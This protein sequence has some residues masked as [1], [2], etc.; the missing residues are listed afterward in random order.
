[1]SVKKSFWARLFGHDKVMNDEN[2]HALTKQ[3]NATIQKSL[4]EQYGISISHEMLSVGDLHEQGFRLMLPDE[5][6]CAS[7]VLQYVPQM[8]VSQVNATA[9]STA[10]RVA[11]DGSYRPIL[12]SQM[13]LAASKMTEGAV[14]G[15][16]LSNST[17]QVAGSAEWVKNTAVSSLTKAPQIALA[18]FSAVS[19]ITGQYFMT[20]INSKLTEL[21]TEVDHLGQFLDATQRSE[22]YAAFHELD[23]IIAR[24]DYIISDEAKA[25]A[26]I[27]QIHD[28]QRAAQKA[29][30]L[31]RDQ[32]EC[33]K[34]LMKTTDKDDV[35]VGRLNTIGK[36]MIEYK[37]A[38][39]L[40]SVATLLEVR[41]S[42][43]TNPDELGKFHSQI[44]SRVEQYKQD[45]ADCEKQLFAY[46][47]QSHVLNDRSLVQ[48]LA[49]AGTVALSAVSSVVSGVFPGL[50]A[51]FAVDDLF[52]EQQKK[53]KD[54]RI[55]LAKRYISHTSDVSSLD[56]PSAAIS[57]FI[58]LVSARIEIVQVGDELYTN[59]PE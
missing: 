15:I 16:G 21:K 39:Q 37:Q 33:E 38:V 26:A 41:F 55:D 4:R 56:A 46:I 57:S 45:N 14:R 13:H 1:M 3:E 36:F 8:V 22:L 59:I 42:N 31:C 35:L 43:I 48:N 17:N 12:D 9:A 20:Q 54:E 25:H 11:I 34:G 23:D 5:A 7:A 47:E 49:T 53:K 44:D 50:H 18:A 10:L 28:I 32:V 51:A 6:A 30:L 2:N 24:A 29:I 58:D 40:Y 27:D 19:L 52:T